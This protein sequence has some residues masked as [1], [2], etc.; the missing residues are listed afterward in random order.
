MENLKNDVEKQIAE[1]KA[2]AVVENPIAELVQPGAMKAWSSVK[3]DPGDRKNAVIL[4]KMLAQADFTANDV[5]GEVLELTN[6]LVHEVDVESDTG[7]R[8]TAYRTVFLLADGKTVSFTSYGILSSL[9]NIFALMGQPPYD[10]AL[11]LTVTQISTR[12]GRRTY[13]IMLVAE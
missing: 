9:R 4:S 7:E 2:L 12:K 5:L 11:K 8:F 3:V 13:N 10:P 1:E 6:I